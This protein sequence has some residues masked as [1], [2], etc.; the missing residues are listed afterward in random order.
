MVMGTKTK[1]KEL[2][3]PK[4]AFLLCLVAL[5]ASSLLITNPS[6][7]NIDASTYVIAPIIMLPLFFA[8][9]LF[10]ENPIP[11]TSI[12]SIMLGFALLIALAVLM[13]YL[14]YSSQYL[15]ISYRIDMLLF[16][17]AAIALISIIYGFSNIRKFR[18]ALIYSVLAS[19]L[20][21]Y[22]VISANSA[23]ASVNSQIIFSVLHTFI[24]GVSF[25]APF[26]ISYNTISIG[27][28]TACA[29]VAVF[30]ALLLFMLP[31]AYLFDGKLSAKAYWLAS[32]IF[33]L[34]ILNLS[35]MA[36][37]AA[38][39]LVKGPSA[40]VSTIHLF[41]GVL[42]FYAAI[43]IMLPAAG[44][45]GLKIKSMKIE[46]SEKVT[47]EPSHVFAYVFA[48][49]GVL[50]YLFA[51]QIFVNTTRVPVLAAMN[52]TQFVAN[53]ITSLQYLHKIVNATGWNAS[54]IYY[55]DGRSIAILFSNEIFN[56]SNPIVGVF[57]A[58][59]SS[60]ISD[61]LHN[62]SISGSRV[63]INNGTIV[64]GYD[65]VSNSTEFFVFSSVLPYFTANTFSPVDTYFIMPLST[66][67]Y[68]KGCAYDSDIYSNLLSFITQGTMNTS[69][70]YEMDNAYC[71]F[72]HIVV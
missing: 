14:Y 58:T 30:I 42:I 47:G 26:S 35:R 6:I 37:I 9:I 11:S 22:P 4:I 24:N 56:Q 53:S 23:F 52:T 31:V 66:G 18:Y 70:M 55:S 45:F 63:F 13:S 54:A 15:F 34:F 60:S 21:F 19:P 64:N 40:V 44:I 48:V 51:S 28:G 50:A 8:F 68:S 46:L 71:I 3:Y 72:K 57:S 59:N 10:K 36:G 25:T 43:L 32:G 17:I 5:L 39:W 27:I 38:V 2:Q 41:I 33:L 7:D 12:K 67:Y 1:K 65:I 69:K 49:I 20:I 62:S 16:P 29:G 61:I